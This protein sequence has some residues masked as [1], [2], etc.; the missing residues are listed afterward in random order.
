MKFGAAS[1]FVYIY[2]AQNLVVF[3]LHI[4][5][6]FKFLSS[7]LQAVSRLLGSCRNY[8][9]ASC[10]TELENMQPH[11]LA[12]HFRD[13]DNIGTTSVEISNSTLTIDRRY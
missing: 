7:Y 11:N 5:V 1:I 8:L 13:K 6:I 3:S 2:C 4:F 12:K 9:E 10:L